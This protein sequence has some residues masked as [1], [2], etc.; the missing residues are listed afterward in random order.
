MS[1]V[2][3]T[4]SKCV[5]N[6]ITL[7]SK[8]S[9][10]NARSSSPSH[11]SY[12]IQHTRYP[13]SLSNNIRLRQ[14]TQISSINQSRLLQLNNLIYYD[15]LFTL[16]RGNAS[17]PKGFLGSLMD[18]IKEEF[19]KNKE[20]KDNIK[21]FRDQA[22]KL[23]DSDAL[24]EARDKYKS[25]ERET[26][27]SSAVLREKLGEIGDK[28]KESDVIKKA[29]DLGYELG[30]QAQKA[31]EKISER[32]EQITDTTA[33]KK[34][35]ERL[36]TI[37]EEVGDATKLTR[38][39]G[40]QPPTTLRKRSDTDSVKKEKVF[41]ADTETQTITVHK[42]S[43]W[44]QSWQNFKENNTYLN[45]LFDLKS[46]YDE[47]DNLVVRVARTFT[48]KVSGALSSIFSQSETSEALTEI[49]RVDP[50]FDVAQFIRVV[51][52]D[53]IPNIFES[54]ARSELEILRDWCTEAVYNVLIHPINTSKAMNYKYHLKIID[55]SDVELVAAKTMEMGPVLVVNFQAQQIAYISDANGKVTEG[56]PE[57]INRINYIFALGR[58]PTILDP[59]SAWRLVDLSASK[60]NHFV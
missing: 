13:S 12:S 22:K 7:S 8:T 42:D 15:P 17:Q 9:T 35:S 23:E 3:T 57:Q 21:K 34:V 43:Q 47:S 38:P 50:A 6:L 55:L 49:C 39:L 53:I 25:L 5:P 40:Y 56:D 4:A 54:L 48:D 27:K 31:A 36:T 33:Y 11:R 18:N 14:P 24:K 28:V 29:S 30:K 44:Y 20:I 26:M 59:L 16:K 19:T 41:H 2:L 58:D 37:K 52:Y 1:K 51:Q 45:K 10:I 46:K 60:V 32:T